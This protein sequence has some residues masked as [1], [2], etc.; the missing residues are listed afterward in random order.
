MTSLLGD[1]LGVLGGFATYV[2][3]GIVDVLNLLFEAVGGVVA[4]L[5][6]LLPHM[7]EATQLTTSEI[8]ECVN[9]FYPLG[10]VAA[11][12]ALVLPLFVAYLVVRYLLQLLRAA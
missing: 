10:E 11:V 1:I 6:L 5:F 12:Y 8:L 4:A 7:P 3:A 9:Y 2:E